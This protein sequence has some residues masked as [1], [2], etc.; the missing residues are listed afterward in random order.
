MNVNCFFILEKSYANF[1]N[2]NEKNNHR[3]PNVK[4]AYIEL[5]SA[6]EIVFV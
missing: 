6:D 2:K 1:R 5:Y 4:G 3:I